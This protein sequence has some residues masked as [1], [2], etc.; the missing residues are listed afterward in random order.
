[1]HFIIVCTFRVIDKKMLLLSYRQEH[2]STQY[3]STPFFLPTYH[4]YLFKCVKI[5]LVCSQH[6]VIKNQPHLA[7]KNRFYGISQKP[8][9]LLTQECS[10]HS[11]N[12]KKNLESGNY[13]A[14]IAIFCSC[15]LANIFVQLVTPSISCNRRQQIAQ[16]VGRFVC[17][18]CVYNGRPGISCSLTSIAF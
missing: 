9:L 17:T 5:C 12:P 8:I 6:I 11:K 4:T 3:I 16:S 7:L 18:L 14:R 1:M 13:R 2:K 10:I 15:S